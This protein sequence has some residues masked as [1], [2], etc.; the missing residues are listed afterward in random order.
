MLFPILLGAV[1]GALFAHLA[2]SRRS[3]ETRVLAVGLAA[4]ALIYVGL[5]LPGAD[6]RWLLLE[7]AGLAVF[8]ALAWLGRS[9]ALWL[10]TGWVA[11]VAWDVGL[12]LDRPQSVVGAWYPLL[13]VGFDLIVAGHLLRAA[14]VAPD[15]AQHHPTGRVA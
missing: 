7:T 3:G 1:L 8:G 15:A 6:P 11:H 5:A 9:S 13:C 2:R 10:A 12:H 4:A 14:P